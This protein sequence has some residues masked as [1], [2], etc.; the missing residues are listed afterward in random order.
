M[1]EPTLQMTFGTN[2]SPLMGKDGK[3]VSARQI[4]AR[5]FAEVQKDV[6]LKFKRIP[7]TETWIVSG[8]GELH[9]SI[10]N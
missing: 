3:F 8:R 5:L 7:N 4:E 10:F 6:A 9:L 1:D 2:T